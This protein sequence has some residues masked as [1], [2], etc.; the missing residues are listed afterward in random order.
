MTKR[1]PEELNKPAAGHGYGRH[2]W[3]RRVRWWGGRLCLAALAPVLALAVLELGLR[4]AGYGHASSFFIRGT[5]SGLLFSNPAY[6]W[7]FLGKPLSRAP[8]PIS[9]RRHKPEGVFRIFVFGESAAMGDLNEAYSFPR[10]LRVMLEQR[11]PALRFEVINT[12]ITAINS[13]AVLPIA[14]ESSAY[15]PDLYIV[16]M[17][18]NEVVGPNGPGTVFGGFES[19][20]PIIRASVLVRGLRIAQMLNAAQTAL[21]TRASPTVGKEFG[22]DLFVDKQVPAGDKRLAA[23]Y[24][25][26]SK[27]LE[28]LCEVGSRAGVPVIVCTLLANLKD[29][30]PFH[31]K[32]RFD[33]S[34][35]LLRKWTAFQEEALARQSAG[36]FTEAIEQYEEAE[37]L[38]GRY[39]D[40]HYRKGQCHLALHEYDEALRCFQTA[41][42]LDTLR[43]RPD[44]RI[45]NTI[46]EVAAARHSRGVRLADVERDV[47]AA[48]ASPDR[49]TGSHLLDDHVH[50]NFEGNYAVAAVVY[51]KVVDVL[52]ERDAVPS[53]PQ[54]PSL[55][56][57]AR[58]LVFTPYHRLRSLREMGRRMLMP[59]FSR[60][61]AQFLKVGIRRLTPLVTPSALRQV[62]QDYRQALADRPDDVLMRASYAEV[63]HLQNRYAEAAREYRQ[64]L[65]YYPYAA[66]WQ[67]CLGVVLVAEGHIE[68]SISWLR[69]AEAQLPDRNLVHV[70]LAGAL[71]TAGQ[72]DDAVKEYQRAL[73]LD[74][75][76]ANAHLGLGRALLARHD[77]AA[78]ERQ[79]KI[80][81]RM[82]P[83]LS[84]G[85]V[86]LGVSLAQQRKLE[87]AIGAFE[88]ALRLKPGL[89]VIQ[90]CLAVAHYQSGHLAEAQYCYDLA[91]KTGAR[92]YE[93]PP[94]EDGGWD[95]ISP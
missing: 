76:D 53:G 59:P 66:D 49:I 70:T 15:D 2:W 95:Q 35:D 13:H 42:D 88:E 75:K 65:Q 68:E 11:F 92:F 62:V 3:H 17:G 43:F 56:E 90:Y 41:C 47:S 54:P 45:N 69:K 19:F 23:V 51:A 7:G 67:Y 21:W 77:P 26:F 1:Q 30:P 79:F 83:E 80:A 14:R 84:F 63:L 58:R 52:A 22:M 28:D 44:T 4:L 33:L 89:S 74:A 87:P 93:W 5:N 10:V 94:E 25:H 73:S 40:L 91:V 78:A 8:I 50:M 82:R 38:D 72:I 64:L 60:E 32:H 9:I 16:Y 46:R 6:S 71:L 31:S 57:C 29:C 81:V 12:A 20:L 34:V 27:N 85:H 37:R 39:A 61:H 24:A 18:N 86:A 36:N 48:D 55:E